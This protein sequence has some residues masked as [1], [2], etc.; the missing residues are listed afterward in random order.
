MCLSPRGVRGTSNPQAEPPLAAGDE[1]GG[2]APG[3]PGKAGPPLEAMLAS[4]LAKPTCPGLP[5]LSRRA[6]AHTYS[7]SQQPPGTEAGP[8]CRGPSYPITQGCSAAPAP[9]SPRR[10]T[11]GPGPKVALLGCRGRKEAGG[12]KAVGADPLP[13]DLSQS[14]KSSFWKTHP[15]SGSGGERRGARRLRGKAPSQD[16][17]CQ[18]PQT[19]APTY[20]HTTHRH[21]HS[22]RAHATQT[23]TEHTCTRHTPSPPSQVKQPAFLGSPG[24][25][26]DTDFRGAPCPDTALPPSPWPHRA[27]RETALPAGMQCAG[28]QR[29]GRGGATSPWRLAASALGWRC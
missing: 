17:A 22:T 14:T 4:L 9:L 16:S 24:L 28:L 11:A 26:P 2:G 18:H 27:P 15:R 20:M 19:C 13:Q 6:S 5:G 10:H 1:P 29:G 8:T 12:Q 23:H 25:L 7:P 21:T 3:T